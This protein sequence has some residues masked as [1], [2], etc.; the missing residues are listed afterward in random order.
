MDAVEESAVVIALMANTVSMADVDEAGDRLRETS[1]IL[2]S[3][4][5]R[6]DVDHV[7]R[8]HMSRDAVGRRGKERR[9]NR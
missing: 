2:R 6:Q 4:H 1:V 9:R 7:V 3:S 8:L 5:E